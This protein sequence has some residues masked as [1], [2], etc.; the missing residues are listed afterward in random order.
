MFGLLVNHNE[1]LSRLV[2]KGYALG[3]DSNHLVV[4]DIPYL[5]EK[6]ELHWGAIVSKMVSEDNVHFQLHNH[7]IWFC[8][9]HPHYADGKRIPNLGGGETTLTLEA[10]D[11]I[12]QRSFSNKHTNGYVDFFDKINSY[13]SMISGAV[14]EKY[15]VIDLELEAGGG[16]YPSQDGFGWTNGVLLALLNKYGIR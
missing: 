1:D 5:D 3:F 12:V 10:E 4:R 11:L 9:S 13:M 15:N 6:G 7:E 14:M 16:E 2:K 8:G